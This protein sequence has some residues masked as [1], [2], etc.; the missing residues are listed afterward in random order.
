MRILART[1]TLS[2]TQNLATVHGH[3]DLYIRPPV[4]DV[5]TFDW[6]ALDKTVEVGYRSTLE[7]LEAWDRAGRP[8]GAAE[9]EHKI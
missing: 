6:N 7:Q 5:H 3:C 8:R 2:S 4:D 1:S 9:M